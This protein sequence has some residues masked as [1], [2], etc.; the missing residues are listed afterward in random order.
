M[1]FSRLTL[2]YFC[3]LSDVYAGHTLDLSSSK[4]A[5]LLRKTPSLLKALP[6]ARAEAARAITTTSAV[7]QKKEVCEYHEN[8]L[9]RGQ[10]PR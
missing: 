3:R 4:M 10:K 1:R 8:G 9:G 5:S 2:A 7:A 6:A